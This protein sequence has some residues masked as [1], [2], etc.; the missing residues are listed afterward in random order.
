MSVFFSKND[1]CFYQSEMKSAFEK[2]G[3]WPSEMIELTS[4]EVAIFFGKPSPENKKLSAD[5]N[6][7]PVFIDI[8]LSQTE[9]LSLLERSVEA[10]ISNV[11]LSNGF[12]SA[13]NYA[14]YVG[15][16]N[17]LRAL[18]EA[19]GA[20]EAEVWMYCKAELEKVT[21]GTRTLPT[22]TEFLAELPVF[23]TPTS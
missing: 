19:L 12:S 5:S 11:V 6:G 9:E 4:N 17:Q 1:L 13:V 14:K 20:H 15:Y 21:V 10:Y 7:R 22:I 3:N 2:A 8:V 18:S 16:P 23:T